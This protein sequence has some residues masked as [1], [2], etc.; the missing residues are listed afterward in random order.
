[1]ILQVKHG[2]QLCN[3]LFAL[4]PT[5]AYAIHEKQRLVVLFQSKQYL[6]YFPNLTRNR[7]VKFFF[8]EDQKGHSWL[9]RL[10][11][12]LSK[13]AQRSI[14][15]RFKRTVLCQSKR[16]ECIIRGELSDRK[17]EK[18]FHFVDGWE[19]RYDVSYIKEERT[20]LLELFKPRKDIAENVEKVFSGFDGVTVGVHVR[21]GDYNEY[22]GGRFYFDDETYLDAIAQIKNNLT[23]QGGGKIRFLICSNEP[24]ELKNDVAEMFQ[25]APLFPTDCMTDLYGLSRCDYII[26]PPS[27]F[28][29]WASYYGHVPL[30]FLRCKGD[31]IT[32]SEFLPFIYLDRTEKG[33][34]PF[35]YE[36]FHTD[37]QP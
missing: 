23:S 1:M 6:E 13:D 35:L 18:G 19:H 33:Y 30:R 10:T 20:A 9:D 2:C 5:S 21:R 3:R 28:S 25:I 37:H 17:E 24:F 14:G 31:Q 15:A 4:L 16:D 8:S 34:D 7:Y 22:C 11:M 27:T 36:V 32:M 29:Q 12:K 26:G